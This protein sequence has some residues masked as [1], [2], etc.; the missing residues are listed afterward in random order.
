MDTKYLIFL[1]RKNPLSVVGILLLS[2]IVICAVLA[3]LFTHYDPLASNPAEAFRPPDSEHWFGTDN[4]GKDIFSR[5]IYGSR[6]DLLIAF[7]SVILSVGIGAPVGAVIGYF[8]GRLDE[9]TMRILDTVQAFPS[10]ILAMAI[11]VTLGQSI[12][13]LICVIGFVNFPSFVRLVRA[14]MMSIRERQYAEAA[15]CVG[16]SSAAIIFRHLLPNCL[17]P[18]IIQASLT[19]GWAIMTA[20]G[21]GFLGLGVRIP[22]PE[23]GSMISVGTEYIISG[24]WWLSFFPGVAI[25]LTVLSF[26]LIGDAIDDILDPKR[27]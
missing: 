14:E 12:V 3:P 21:L 23:W 19:S 6:Y 22:N 16:N 25:M 1:I 8:G 18:V 5:I 24:E 15:R 17:S 9:Y 13:N 20:A 7:A 10:F 27:R 2:A 26:N 4:T 11:L